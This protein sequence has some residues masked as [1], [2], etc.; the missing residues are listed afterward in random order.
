MGLLAYDW[1]RSLLFDFFCLGKKF[2]VFNLVSRNLKIKYRRSVFGVFWTLLNP[3]ALTCI[4]Y[5]IFKIIMKSEVPHYPA[6]MMSGVLVWSFFA[7]TVLEG[8][9]SI[10]GNWGL[11]SKVPIPVQVFPWVG[12]I[13]N[14][15]TLFLALPIVLG[16]AYLSGVQLCGSVVLLF[17]YLGATFLMSY[18]VSLV[19]AIAFVYLRDLRHITGLIVQLWFFGTPVLYDEAM[20]PEKYHWVLTFNPL[21]Y[22]FIGIHDVLIRGIWPAPRELAIVALWT[23]V[24]MA[25]SVAFFRWLAREVVERI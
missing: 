6:F 13:T 20:I 7:S 18:C 11:V 19:L 5:F 24:V 12:T 22:I 14:L 15:I 9:E 17:F 1:R 8:L 2:L 25:F 10:V 21:A 16:A 4:Y 23:V 3:L